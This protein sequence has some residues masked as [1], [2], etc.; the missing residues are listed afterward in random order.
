MSETLRSIQILLLRLTQQSVTSLRIQDVSLA[1]LQDVLA[2]CR[3]GRW[4]SWET[5]AMPA[6]REQ[7]ISDTSMQDR[8]ELQTR[9]AR[10]FA[11]SLAEEIKT[12][13]DTYE[14]DKSSL[15]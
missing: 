8:F 2:E 15:P 10:D 3:A 11:Y 4:L 14:A 6:L 9:N 12:S 5:I 7:G 13:Q 1:L